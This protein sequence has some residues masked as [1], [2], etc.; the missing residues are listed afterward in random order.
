[1]FG[2]LKEF[3]IENL[4]SFIVFALIYL[5]LFYIFKPSLIFLNTTVSG[6]DTGS[7]NYLFY[8]L[9]KIFPSIHAWSHDWYYGSIVFLI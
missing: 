7:H 8:Y 2:K 5:Y 4:A 6:G 9:K 1:M 3:I